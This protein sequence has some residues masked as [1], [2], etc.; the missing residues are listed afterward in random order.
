MLGDA[1]PRQAERP[2]RSEERPLKLTLGR[3]LSKPVRPRRPPGLSD[4]AVLRPRRLQRL[5]VPPLRP[6]SDR[7]EERKGSR[8]RSF[9][10]GADRQPGGTGRITTKG[11][12]ATPPG[13]PEHARE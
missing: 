1:E 2:V 3:F 10:P 12:N 6:S 5:T 13:S 7:E 9:Q 11:I 8:R 4:Q